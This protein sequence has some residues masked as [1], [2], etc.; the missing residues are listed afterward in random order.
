MQSEDNRVIW[1]LLIG[2]VALIFGGTMA[3]LWINEPR[4][5]ASCP[6]DHRRCP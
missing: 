4:A 2:W 5:F 1:I 3:V 6:F